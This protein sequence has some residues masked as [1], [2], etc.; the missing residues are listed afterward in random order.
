MS[1]INL[2]HCRIIDYDGAW[3]SAGEFTVNRN[4]LMQNY[5]P[6]RFRQHN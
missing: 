1:R 3:I 2:G 4:A 6:A 5:Q